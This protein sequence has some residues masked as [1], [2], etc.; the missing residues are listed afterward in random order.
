MSPRE[1]EAAPSGLAAHER[2]VAR[3]LELLGLPPRAW[4]AVRPGPDGAPL[5]DVVVVGAG[6]CGIAAAAGLIFKGVRNIRVLDQSPA[7]REGPWLNF[8]RMTTL[9]SPKHLPGPALGIP[10]L[11]FRAWYE[12]LHGAEGWAQL[13]K[14]SRADWM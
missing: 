1:T 4:S 11:T 7:G 6:M 2:E 10:S 13:Y 9:R 5:L 3:D 8:A 12:A 14:I